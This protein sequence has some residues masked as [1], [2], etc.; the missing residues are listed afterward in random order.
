MKKFIVLFII[1]LINA[2]TVFAQNAEVKDFLSRYEQMV[3]SFEDINTDKIDSEKVDSIKVVYKKLTKEV[4]KYKSLMSNDELENYYALKAR[5]QKKL[6][7]LKAK[8]SASA[9]KGWVKGMV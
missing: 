8:R 7:V 3:T 2:S 4:N 5:Y 6:T 9:I 1:V